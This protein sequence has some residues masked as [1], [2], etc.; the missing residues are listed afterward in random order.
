M[1]PSIEM[2]RAMAR[3]HAVIPVYEEILADLETPVT[4]YL[5]LSRGTNHAFLLESVEKTDVIGRYSFLG[6]APSVIFRSKGTRGEIVRD[7]VTEPLETNDPLGRLRDLM[8]TYQPLPVEGV[9]AFHGGAVGYIS[10]DTVRFFEKLPDLK[11]D[12]LNLPDLYFMITDTL[13]VF[14]H[15]RNKILIISNAHVDGEPDA[16]YNEAARKIMEIRQKLRGPLMVSTERIH[17]AAGDP[18]V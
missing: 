16:A 8:K 6:A 4:A 17:N 3:P 18:P 1:Y 12:P 2:F 11:P 9:P 15:V 14:D 5:K 13:V 10:Y 7:G